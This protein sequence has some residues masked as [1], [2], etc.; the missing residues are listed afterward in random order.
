MLKQTSMELYIF[1]F[2]YMLY[3]LIEVIVVYFRLHPFQYLNW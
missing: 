1:H 2:V 3:M